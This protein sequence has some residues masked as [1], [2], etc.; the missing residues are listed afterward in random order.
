MEEKNTSLKKI[1]L[2][3]K[4]KRDIPS[5]GVPCGGHDDYELPQMK[6]VRYYVQLHQCFYAHACMCTVH[7][8]YKPNFITCNFAYSLIQ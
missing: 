1:W 7:K 4:Y 3:V 6:F 5:A 2:P 8:H